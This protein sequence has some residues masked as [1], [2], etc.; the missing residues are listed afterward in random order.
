MTPELLHAKNVIVQGITGNQGSFHALVMQ[1]SG[2]NIV[3]GTSPTKAGER[4]DKIPVFADIKS[5]KAN[6]IRIDASVIF[7]PAA[8]A[9]SAIV[10][11]ID[12]HVPLIVCITEGVPVHDMLYIK[13]YM[14]GKKVSSY[15]T[16]YPRNSY[17]RHPSPWYYSCSIFAARRYGNH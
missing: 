1:A 6:G 3:A 12:E 9:K 14:K 2:T 13:Q 4:L 17:S 8:N 5:I 11:A 15:W 7:V 16:Q 10:E